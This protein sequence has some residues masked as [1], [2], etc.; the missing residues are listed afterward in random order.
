MLNT[1]LGAKIHWTQPGGWVFNPVYVGPDTID[2]TVAKGPHAG[3]H[4]VQHAHFHRVAPGIELTS[5]YEE[6]GT[7]V[8]VIWYLESQTTHRF[9]ALPAWA[10]EDYSVLVGDNRDPQYLAHIR[11]LAATKPDG[12]RHLLSDDGYFEVLQRV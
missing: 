5:W 6:T 9:A 1:I 12:P 10:V 4:A 11:K 8:N 3:R 2:Y 7:V